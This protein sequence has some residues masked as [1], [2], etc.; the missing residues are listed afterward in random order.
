[1]D[2]TVLSLKDRE[3]FISMPG[4]N[5]F[6]ERLKIAMDGLSNVALASSCDISESAVRSYLKGRSYPSIDKIQAIAEACDAP[7]I[8]LITGE[9]VAEK[10]D[11]SVLFDDKQ[12]GGVLNLMTKEQRR[13][14]MVAIIEHGISGILN[15]LRGI[16]SLSEFLM[17]PENERQQ[18]LRLHGEV[19]KGAHQGD[20]E[21]EQPNLMGNDRQIG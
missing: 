10:N 11:S 6:A 9:E 1:M 21:P 14:L 7:L 17:L 4:I 12:M 19:K 5:R 13:Q 15:A 2:K 18:L 16:E 8:W 3:R 20:Q